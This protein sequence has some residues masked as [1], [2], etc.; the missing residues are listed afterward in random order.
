M[1]LY[2]LGSVFPG[3]DVRDH[4]IS[5]LNVMHIFWSPS[6]VKATNLNLSLHK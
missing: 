1:S 3:F 6:A 4:F 2:K 5:Y